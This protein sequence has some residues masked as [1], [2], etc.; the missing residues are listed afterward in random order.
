MQQGRDFTVVFRSFGDDIADVVEEMNAFATG[1][2]PAYP[3]VPVQRAFAPYLLPV[4][5]LFAS[6]LPPVIHRADCLAPFSDM[7]Y[8]FCT[9]LVLTTLSG[10]VY[11]W[12]HDSLARRGVKFVQ[13]R[14]LCLLQMCLSVVR[15]VQVRMDG[16]D[17]Q[18][19][20][21]MSM[22]DN[23]GAFYRSSTKPDGTALCLGDQLNHLLMTLQQLVLIQCP[24]VALVSRPHIDC[25]VYL[26]SE[27]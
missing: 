18:T 20:L 16:S 27:T 5:L 8:H 13:V 26:Y 11:L 15:L 23:V 12:C 10:T 21:R 6:H 19:D 14:G 24:A 7:P 2:H 22:P 9:G 17:G 1:Q 3:E 25:R 4:C